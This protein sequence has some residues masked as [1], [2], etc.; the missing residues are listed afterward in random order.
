MNLVCAKPT[1]NSRPISKLNE[2]TPCR[3]YHNTGCQS[4]TAEI[5]SFKPTIVRV[6]SFEHF[7]VLEVSRKCQILWDQNNTVVCLFASPTWPATHL[8]KK[9]YHVNYS[10]VLRVLI[11]NAHCLTSIWRRATDEC[12]WRLQIKTTSTLV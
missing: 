11:P 7:S 9:S 3:E 5:D 1:R 8:E 2:L 10:L 4:H 6:T 12:G